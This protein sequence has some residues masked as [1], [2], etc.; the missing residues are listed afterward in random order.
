MPLLVSNN[1][2]NWLSEQEK[3]ISL[4][5]FVETI[6]FEGVNA[7]AEGSFEIYFNDHNLFGG[8]TI[9]VDINEIFELEDANIAG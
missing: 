2:R 5:E 9:I 7:F 6:E 4:N 8:H 1:Y 3:P